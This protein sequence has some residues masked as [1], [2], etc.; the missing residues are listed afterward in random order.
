MAWTVE[1][2][3]RLRVLWKEG[4]RTAVIAKDPWIRQ[5]VKSK[6]GVIHKAAELGLGPHPKPWRGDKPP[7]QIMRERAARK[8]AADAAVAR[9]LRGEPVLG[10]TPRTRSEINSDWRAQKKIASMVPNRRHEPVMVKDQPTE[11]PPDKSD[12][13]VPFR[14]LEDGMCKY[15][16]GELFCGSPTKATYCERHHK[17]TKRK[18]VARHGQAQ[19]TRNYRRTANGT[20]YY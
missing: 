19:A 7:A 5:C 9:R 6:G 10:R 16:V 4:E 1:A 18:G 8:A 14:Q 3:N 20:A 11:L 13:A 17:L 2:E 15:P 12:C